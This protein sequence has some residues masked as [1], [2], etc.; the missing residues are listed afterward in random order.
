MTHLERLQKTGIKRL[1]TAKRGFRYATA[2]GTKVSVADAKR[3]DALRIPPAWI[4]VA[5]N[6]SANGHLQVVGKDAAGRWQYLYHDQPGRESRP[7]LAPVSK[8]RRCKVLLELEDHL[9]HRRLF[10]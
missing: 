9:D 8:H 10:Q 7:M 4:D 6:S 2:N 3:I 1:G 5:I